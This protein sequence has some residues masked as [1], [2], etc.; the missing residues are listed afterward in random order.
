[1]SIKIEVIT[2]YWLEEFLAPLFLLHYAHW[3]DKITMLTTRFPEDKFDDGLKLD[4]INNAIARS[5]A[6]WVIAVDFD[7]FV[8]PHHNA[9]PRQVL[10][11][12]TGDILNCEMVRVWRHASDQDIDRMKPPLP[13]RQHGEKDHVKPCIFRPRG[14][15]LDIG[16]HG[17]TTPRGAVWGVPWRAAHWANADPCFG[18]ERSLLN[19]QLRLSQNQIDHGW[20]IVPQWLD[21]KFLPEKYLQHMEDPIVL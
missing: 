18:I 20:G 2:T 8:F 4:L 10:E 19:R 11:V 16:G 14:V 3:T 13:Q 6:D 17:S 15:K 5:D 12:E 9:N 7:E 21:P 1:M